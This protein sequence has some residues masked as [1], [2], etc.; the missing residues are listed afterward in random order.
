MI[1]PNSFLVQVCEFGDTFRDKDLFP[2][3]PKRIVSNDESQDMFA[4][5][6]DEVH[7]LICIMWCLKLVFWLNL[8]VQSFPL[9][10]QDYFK[11][12]IPRD[13]SSS[14]EYGHGLWIGAGFFHIVYIQ[15]NIG[16]SSCSGMPKSWSSHFLEGILQTPLQLDRF[17]RWC[18]F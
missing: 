8:W 4:T 16:L 17:Q 3:S 10:N 15:I 2:H 9:E 1:F 7:M 12:H 18:Y 5:M 13:S 14:L 6:D 11:E